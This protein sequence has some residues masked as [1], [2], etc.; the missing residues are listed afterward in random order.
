MMGKYL[1]KI[2]LDKQFYDHSQPDAGFK[3]L[4]KYKELSLTEMTKMLRELDWT[5]N[6]ANGISDI[7]YDLSI[8]EP[9]IDDYLYEMSISSASEALRVC[10][11]LFLGWDISRKT[12]RQRE[13]ERRAKA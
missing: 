8:Y 4:T 6:A 12:I 7:R 11:A 2:K 5:A 9:I 13:M 1:I 3:T 10:Q